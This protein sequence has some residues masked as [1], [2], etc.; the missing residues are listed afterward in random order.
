MSALAESNAAHGGRG[1]AHACTY[2]R[3]EFV[4][5]ISHL[6]QVSEHVT[7]MDSYLFCEQI[8]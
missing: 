8:G 1:H 7:C 3:K 4:I 5:L 2:E 6:F